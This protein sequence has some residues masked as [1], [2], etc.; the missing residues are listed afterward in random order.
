M[1]I[2]LACVSG[3]AALYCHELTLCV[4]LRRTRREPDT[5]LL[6]AA[7]CVW[8][9]DA[10]GEHLHTA[11]PRLH[12]QAQDVEGYAAALP[13]AHCLCCSRHCQAMASSGATCS[14]CQ[15]Q[16]SIAQHA[17]LQLRRRCCSAC[18]EVPYSC[19]RIDVRPVKSVLIQCV[20]AQRP[21]ASTDALVLV[22]GRQPRSSSRTS[23]RASS[24]RGSRISGRQ[25]IP[26]QACP[27]VQLAFAA[28][29]QVPWLTSL[30]ILSSADAAG[31]AAVPGL[32]LQACIHTE[33]GQ[34]RLACLC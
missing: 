22:R 29:A 30:R 27:H 7:S 10:G 26:A 23:I 21:G 31:L 5:R 6:A 17:H 24:S 28:L 4:C 8:Q 3:G 9:D 11:K 12:Q 18:T 33:Q 13:A 34:Q 20:P 2:E 19:R 25:A 14:V 15:H 1:V 32:R 16:C